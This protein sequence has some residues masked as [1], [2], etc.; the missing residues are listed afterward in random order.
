LRLHAKPHVIG[1]ACVCSMRS[2][3]PRQAPAAILPSSLRPNRGHGDPQPLSAAFGSC[4][5]AR[6]WKIPLGL[7]AHDARLEQRPKIRRHLSTRFKAPRSCIR[8]TTTSR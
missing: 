4:G 6:E 5:F 2:S 3:K 8:E 7:L 1:F